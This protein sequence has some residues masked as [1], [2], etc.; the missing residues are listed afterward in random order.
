M[1]I[2]ITEGATEV[3]VELARPGAGNRLDT[4]TLTDLKNLLEDLS[5]R[6]QPPSVL[7][8]SGRGSD[9]CLGRERGPV[10]P[11]PAE[12]VR[13]FS[14]IQSVNQLMQ[15]CPCVTIAAL[16][17]RALGAGLSLA[18][19]CDIV[20]A[21]DSARLSFPE[22]RNGIPPTIVLSHY[23]YVIPRN[24][25][26]DLILTGRELTSTEAITAGLVSR[27]VPDTELEDVVTALSEE[28][29]HYDRDTI[30]TVKQ[31]LRVTEDIPETQVSALGISLYANVMASRA[32]REQGR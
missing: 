31:F 6:E 20:V 17:G 8:L 5:A 28:V 3:R 22:V 2:A 13:E 21:G 29:A 11:D 18:A 32:R 19:R 14:L 1:T 27:V 7:I 24:L 9:F 16:H 26:G 12:I 10:D 23:R 4:K 30:A 15:Q 25:L